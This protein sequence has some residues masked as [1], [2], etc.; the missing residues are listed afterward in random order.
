M[1][2]LICDDICNDGFKLEQAI[3][4]SHIEANCCYFDKGLDALSH[5]KTGT[6][7]D[8][9]FLDIVMPEMNG[10]ELA[11]QIRKTEDDKGMKS[12]EIVFLTTSN[13]F[14]SESFEVKAFSYLL[15]PL[16]QQKV[17]NT[18]QEIIALK[19]TVDIS[20]ISI[21][22]KIIKKFL[23]C[24]EISFIEVMNYKVYFH[25]IDGSKIAIVSSLG[26]IL[27]QIMVDKRFA[28]CHRSF[29]VNMDE[30]NKIQD[31][32]VLMCSGKRIS[33]SR[34]YVDFCNKYAT[35]LIKAI[36]VLALGGGKCKIYLTFYC[37][38]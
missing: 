29:V 17:A 36:S 16:E 28:Q 27:P 22:T 18:L 12:C 20:G 30:I 33:I 10:I 21:I 3:K 24:R 38:W 11:R 13:G 37:R 9:C 19:K 25:L 5:I 32:S 2:I 35:Y 34:T 6:K 4:A 15:K 1:N 31:N 8:V 14:A 26:A 23:F 7:V